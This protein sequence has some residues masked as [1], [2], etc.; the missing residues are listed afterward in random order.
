VT[1]VVTAPPRPSTRSDPPYERIFRERSGQVLATL[2]RVLGDF[3]LA[4]DALQEA[5]LTALER[6]PADGVPR[7]PAAWLLTVA[8]RKAVD[9]I[10]REARRDEKQRAAAAGTA[11]PGPPDPEEVGMSAIAD[12]RLRLVFTCCHPALAPE[13]QVALTLRTLG[14]LTTTEI[15]RAFLVPEATMAQRLVRA[16]KKIRAAGIPY[17]VPPDHVLPDRLPP[18]LAVLYLIFTEGYAATAGDVLV[19]RELCAEAIRLARV[20]RELMPDEDE[21]AGLLALM[22]LHD[23]RRAARVDAAGD[24]VLLADQDRSRWDRDEIAEGLA[25]LEGALRRSAGSGGV[26][27]YQLEA[28]IVAVHAEATDA[29]STD[30][31]QVAALYGQLARVAPNPV[32]ELNRAVAVAMA[33]GPAAGLARL[34]DLAAGG[35]LAAHHRYHVARAELLVRL[36]RRGEAAAAYDAALALEMPAAERRHLEARRAKVHDA[37]EPDHPTD[38]GEP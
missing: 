23:A 34:D 11:P 4:E 13:A 38:E 35:A 8:R 29:A 22:L 26:G 16:K 36:D 37:H 9:R 27:P 33:D 5:F 12:D 24:L 21:V 25:L 10:R 1:G 20:L 14:G 3:D 7:E 2:I 15:A 30:W 19:R 18:V 17:A 28:A 32:V 31:R 6:W